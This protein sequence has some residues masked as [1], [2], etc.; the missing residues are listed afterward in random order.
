TNIQTVNLVDTANP[1]TYEVT[2]N[3]SDAAGNVATEVVRTV[4]VITTVS[5]NP[6]DSDS[7]GGAFGALL[8]LGLILMAIRRRSTKGHQ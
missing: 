5:N 6:D 3:V 1:G 7:G 4:N 2:Y 8:G